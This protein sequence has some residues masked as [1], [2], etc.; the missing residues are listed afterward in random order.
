[1]ENGSTLKMEMW[2]LNVRH[3]LVRH[4]NG[5]QNGSQKD[6]LVAHYFPW[7][8]RVRREMEIN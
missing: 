8:P 4:I 6:L 7:K 2:R 1:M 5:S 3:S